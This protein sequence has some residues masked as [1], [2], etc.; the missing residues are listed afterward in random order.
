LGQAT[1]FPN[2]VPSWGF[3]DKRYAFTGLSN[4]LPDSL[5]NCGL[6]KL[7]QTDSLEFIGYKMG[8]VDDSAL[9]NTLPPVTRTVYLDIP[10][11]A[12]QTGDEIAVPVILS[13]PVAGVQ[14]TLEHPGLELVSVRAPV[15]SPKLLPRTASYPALQSTAGAWATD[16]QP[17]NRPACTLVFR[18]KSTSTLQA[19]LRLSDKVTAT[20]AFASLIQTPLPGERLRLALRYTTVGTDVTTDLSKGFYAAPN[21]PNPFRS[22]TALNFYLPEADHVTAQITDAAGRI[23]AQSRAF[24][25]AGQQRFSFED[26][27]SWPSGVLYWQLTCRV[28]T[29]TGKMVK[30]E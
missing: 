2:N 25:A 3:I 24:F 12:F 27:R 5:R 20:M 29:A 19:A 18:A 14:F 26:T 8:D 1:A 6:L 13:E 17:A 22:A 23:V 30:V 16:D 11:Q 10:D 4:P 15:A 9:P 28:G 7:P 21:R